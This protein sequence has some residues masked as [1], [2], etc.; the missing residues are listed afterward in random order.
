MKPLRAF[1]PLRET[2]PALYIAD[3]GPTY[4]LATTATVARGEAQRKGW[5]AAAI[6]PTTAHQTELA[7]VDV[8]N[9]TTQR[10]RDPVADYHADT[11]RR[12]TE[13]TE[14]LF[15]RHGIH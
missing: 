15:T 6:R 7:G 10:A 12:R 8:F 3:N 13:Y 14:T 2:A 5:T 11:E 1:A 9:L 4:A